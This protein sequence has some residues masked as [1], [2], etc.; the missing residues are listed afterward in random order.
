MLLLPNGCSCSNISVYPKNWR[1]SKASME[2]GWYINY[3]FYDPTRP[4]PKQVMVRGMNEY[5]E[6]DA[7]RAA[8]ET[9]LNHEIDLLMNQGYNPFVGDCVYPDYGE[10]MVDPNTPFIKAMYQV[11]R[12]IN[13][14]KTTKSDIKSVIRGVEKAAV[15]LS[16]TTIAIRNITR[17]HFKQIFV[18][19]EKVV[20][21]WSPH[22]F[23][24]YR[25][26]L[27]IIFNELMEFE[28]TQVDPMSGIKKLRTVK[29]LRAV[30]TREQRQLVNDHL[31]KKSYPFWR[32]MQIFFHSGARETE[33]L[34]VKKTDVDIEGQ[35]YKV[36]IKKGA[37]HTEVWKVIK[38]IALPLW[39]E[40]YN[41]AGDSDYLFSRGLQPG[42]ALIRADQITRRWRTHVKAPKSKGGLE[43]SA[44]FYS[45]KHL[46]LDETSAALS[47]ADAAKMASHTTPVI[48]LN[49]YLHGEK[50][51]QEERLKKVHNNFS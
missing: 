16:M 18:E 10:G 3:R 4:K 46:N 27:K 13:R 45:L 31:L 15:R 8:T 29:K 44:D 23:N 47:A 2:K 22:R 43:I 35:R 50:G 25:S 5:T 11:H 26:Y 7:R 36:L 49:H 6:R 38:D 30:L 48:T 39:E 40:I 24:K 20:P 37:Q 19:C 17:R 1:T 28:A 21:G 33:L 34:S 42:A 14:S 51:R 41:A 12:M 9:L 32:F